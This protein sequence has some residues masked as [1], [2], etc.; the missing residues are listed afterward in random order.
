MPLPKQLIRGVQDIRTHAGKVDTFSEP[1]RVYMKITTLEMEKARRAK[2]RESAMQRV[3]K[4][5]VRFQEIEAEKNKLL[6][7]LDHADAGRNLSSE[8]E[9]LLKT[10][11]LRS[12]ANFTIKY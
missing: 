3:R 6:Q 10:S 8:R 12:T 2:E 9:H 5:D 1:Y 7:G 11:D 4:I